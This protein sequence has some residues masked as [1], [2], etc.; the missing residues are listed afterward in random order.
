MRM[1]EAAYSSPWSTYK[2]LL[3][4][5]KPYRPL[6]LLALIGMLLEAAAGGGV[7]A[8]VAGGDVIYNRTEA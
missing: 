8:T 2:R 4:T 3:A 6:L 5:A 7:A 1:T